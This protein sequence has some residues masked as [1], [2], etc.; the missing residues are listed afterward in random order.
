MSQTRNETGIKMTHLSEFQSTELARFF[1]GWKGDVNVQAWGIRQWV[2]HLGQKTELLRAMTLESVMWSEFALNLSDG[3]MGFLWGL[4]TDGEKLWVDVSKTIEWPTER[5]VLTLTVRGRN[6]WRQDAN[7]HRWEG[8]GSR[9]LEVARMYTYPTLRQ[10][11]SRYENH[12]R[13][14]SDAMKY[15]IVH[16]GKIAK[17]GKRR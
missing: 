14:I 16:H 13:G 1:K 7:G 8:S 17:K 10:F 6:T 2:R 15:Q 12:L 5:L 4:E 11:E 9:P 3:W